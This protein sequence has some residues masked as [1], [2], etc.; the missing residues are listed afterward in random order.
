[1]K[2]EELTIALAD[3][4]D[5][6]LPDARLAKRGDSPPR[7]SLL[8]ERMGLLAEPSTQAQQ[9][10]R[11]LE[12]WIAS[13]LDLGELS[14]PKSSSP[15]ARIIEN[16]PGLKRKPKQNP[17]ASAGA[18]T[19]DSWKCFQVAYKRGITIVRLM[20][21]ALVKESQVR[22]LARDLLDL[23][24][25]GNHRVILNFQAM[26]R[27]ASWMAFVVDEAR[28]RCAD[29]D[30]GA[31]KICGLP[32]ELA[33]MFAIAGV[34][35]GVSIHENEAAAIESLWPPY[36]GPRPLPVE[37]LSALTR[38]ADVLPISGGAPSEAADLDPLA[39]IE[40]E[41]FLDGST[42]PAPSSECTV[43]L[44]VQI[45]TA[46]GREIAIY[47]PR[48][49][50]GRDRSCHLRLGSAMV[51]KLHA[52]IELRDGK[53]FVRDSGSTN[54]TIVDGRVFRDAEVE[55]RD[56][57]RVQVG[58]AVCTLAVG[59]D[60]APTGPV[61]KIIAGWLQGEGAVSQ[62]YH[63]E[64]QQT[65]SFPTTGDLGAE[66]DPSEDRIKHEII[67][68]VLVVTPRIGE[69]DDPEA[70]EH[71]RSQFHYLFEQPTPRQVVLNLEFVHHLN[72][73]AI[74]VVLAHHFRLDRAGGALRLCQ[75]PARVM[76][77]LHQVRLT[78][79]VECHPTLDEAVLAAWPGPP[80]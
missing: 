59:H 67:Q 64:S 48:F 40:D 18:S 54:G 44:R 49:V 50:I 22:E 1:M 34:G 77:V 58:P 38:A 30:G 73:Q 3:V 2:H 47:G 20:E 52:A 79:L 31:L 41:S 74:G 65:I 37:I 70:I 6:A 35:V 9:D 53:V 25:A 23:I 56:G 36:S 17:R 57:A 24:S 71:L 15:W 8:S 55:I 66:Q 69:L 19:L 7:T 29:G 10:D 76:A 28:R 16:L 21:K 60:K 26:E 5:A 61:E 4:D 78:M 27:V 12:E 42:L 14:A 33:R 51:S 13:H 63:G 62:P 32:P 45:G 80:K 11:R 46:T 43:W 68:N 72:A 75:T 39:S